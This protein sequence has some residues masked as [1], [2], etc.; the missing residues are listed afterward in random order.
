MV[1]KSVST[2]MY[3]NL[4]VGFGFGFVVV[5]RGLFVGR[6]AP[7]NLRTP[8]GP[9]PDLPFH[10]LG[11]LPHRSAHSPL[12]LLLVCLLNLLHLNLPSLMLSFRN[13]TS[14]SNFVFILSFLSL[15]LNVSLASD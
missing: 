11:R 14:S 9:H 10:S 2:A 8:D 7:P 13:L 12:I 3:L 6:M 5:A 1:R 4:K 15:L